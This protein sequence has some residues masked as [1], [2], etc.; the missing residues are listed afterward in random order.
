VTLEEVAVVVELVGTI[1]WLRSAV[2]VTWS[3]LRPM[4]SAPL[5]KL[6]VPVI[7]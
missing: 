1:D 2:A 5:V 3:P 6:K 4:G 7:V